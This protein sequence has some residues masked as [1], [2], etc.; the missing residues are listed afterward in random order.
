MPPGA[1]DKSVTGSSAA[2]P[3]A[4]AV[5][6]A[7][8]IDVATAASATTTSATSTMARP[9][10]LSF[11]PGSRSHGHDHGASRRRRR[12]VGRLS[13]CLFA[14][15]AAFAHTNKV[16]TGQYLVWYLA[17]LPLVWPHLVFR[18]RQHSAKGGG[19]GD[20]D[21]AGGGGGGDDDGSDDVARGN[22][23]MAA[24]SSVASSATPG[25]AAA[26]AWA[27]ASMAGAAWI[28]ALLIWLATAYRL[29]F[30]GHDVWAA[31]WLA[32]GAVQAASIALLAVL[33]RSYQDPVC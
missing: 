4:V 13:L 3:S 19:T 23:P 5:A 27:P 31:L 33:I 17:W 26:R 6:S 32:S 24:A 28:G 22:V 10:S 9:A 8:R 12:L 30:L 14:T 18:P 25:A 20:G 16:L 15:T 7:S 1:I 11:Q 2:A 29:E 21:D